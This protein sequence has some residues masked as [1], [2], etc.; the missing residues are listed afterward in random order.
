MIL[1]KHTSKLLALVYD[2]GVSGLKYGVLVS[3]YL[4]IECVFF[5]VDGIHLLFYFLLH[6][7]CCNLW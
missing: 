1:A 5:Q 4:C 3:D 2:R 7:H 6:M